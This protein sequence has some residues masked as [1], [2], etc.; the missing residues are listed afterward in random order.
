MELIEDDAG[1]TFREAY[2]VRYRTAVYVLHVKKSRPGNP[3]ARH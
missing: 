3:A 1:G 2:T